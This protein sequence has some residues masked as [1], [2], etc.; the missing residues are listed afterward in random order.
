MSDAELDKNI[1]LTIFIWNK[2]RSTF[3]I[4]DFKIWVRKGNNLIY[5]VDQKIK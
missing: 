2:G 3:Y 4:D 1:E 5:A